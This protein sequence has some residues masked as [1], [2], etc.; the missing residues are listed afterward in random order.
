[1][2]ATPLKRRVDFVTDAMIVE[3]LFEHKVVTATQVRRDVMP[4]YKLASVRNRLLKLRNRKI[5]ESQSLYDLGRVSIYSL[6]KRGFNGFIACLLYTSPSPRDRT[7]S[8][9]PSSA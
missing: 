5:V 4:H 6:T 9:M 2:M 8:R 1:M 7:R 3:Y